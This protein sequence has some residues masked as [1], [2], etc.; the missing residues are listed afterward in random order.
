MSSHSVSSGVH[1]TRSLA[2]CVCFVNRCLSFC[3]FSF[4]YYVVYSS[5]MY[6]FWLPLWYLQ[7]LLMCVDRNRQQ[8]FNYAT[9]TWLVGM[10]ED[11]A[12]VSNRPVNQ[13]SWMGVWKPQHLSWATEL[14]HTSVGLDLLS[15][16]NNL[17]H[18][19]THAP[20][21]SWRFARYISTNKQICFAV[22][23]RKCA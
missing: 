9:T 18:S 14:E 6:G 5:S 22:C 16:V 2:L 1:V 21:S 3:P 13:Q 23:T 12:Y 11:R 7:T 15:E 17:N 20:Q 8:Y 19:A 4:G 10:R